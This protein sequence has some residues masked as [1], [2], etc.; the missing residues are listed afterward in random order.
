MHIRRKGYGKFA[1][2][3]LVI[4]IGFLA[5]GGLALA[6]DPWQPDDE[7]VVL[8][9]LDNLLG[10]LAAMVERAKIAK[11]AHPEFIKDLENMVVLLKAQRDKIAETCLSTDLDQYS[12]EYLH[13]Q[14][15][16]ITGP[17]V[18]YLGFV[19]DRVGPWHTAVPD[20]ENDASFQML[21][22]FPHKVEIR[23]IQLYAS[24][25]EGT[26]GSSWW[27]SHNTESWIL[28]VFHDGKML[29]PNREESLG[30]FTGWV[31]LEL[32]GD[33]EAGCFENDRYLLFE[34]TTNEGVLSKLYQVTHLEDEFARP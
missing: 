20:G 11:A 21:V 16:E 17:D 27:H 31:L 22:Y 14:P 13:S 7:S 8:E 30:V 3:V 15:R 18:R 29:N 9:D 33:D 4:L 32:Y 5:S 1:V 19:E 28:G 26:K 10:Q 24:N 2:C 34:I 23:N 12:T 25:S 6:Y